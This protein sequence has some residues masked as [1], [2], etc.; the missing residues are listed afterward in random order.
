MSFL[1]RQP[2]WVLGLIGGGIAIGAY[3]ITTGQWEGNSQIQMLSIGLS[4]IGFLAMMTDDRPIPVNISEVIQSNYKLIREAQAKGRVPS[5]SL[6][7]LMEARK[8]ITDGKPVY[9]EHGVQV[10]N[11]EQGNPVY[12]IRTE[13]LRDI[14]G[15]IDI[16]GM[17]KEDDWNARKRPDTI[18]IEPP[19]MVTF[20]RLRRAEEMKR[21]VSDE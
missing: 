10:E 15:N 5:G 2:K 4:A 3:A 9:W 7:S 14:R 8:V 18:V 19:D 12:V 13:L 1:S 16:S 11:R 20:L 21:G 17:T 6:A